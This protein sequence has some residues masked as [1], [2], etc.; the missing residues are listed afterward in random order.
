MSRVWRPRCPE[1]RREMVSLAQIELD[2]GHVT[3]EALL[4]SYQAYGCEACGAT[5]IFDLATGKRVTAE[6]E[7][8]P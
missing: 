3:R 1:C 7:V 5:A 4:A 2:L 8:S 6:V